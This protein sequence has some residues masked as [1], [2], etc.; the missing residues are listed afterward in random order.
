MHLAPGFPTALMHSARGRI[1]AER[2]DLRRGVDELMRCGDTLRA[3]G[4]E[5]PGVVP[6]RSDAAVLL[7]IANDTE[8]AREL[9][10]AEVELAERL[11]GPI[12]RGRAMHALAQTYRGAERIELLREALATLA[13]SPAS[14]S[15]AM[16]AV[17]LGATLRRAKQPGEARQFLADGLDVAGRCRCAPLVTRAREELQVLGVAPRRAPAYGP[18]SLTPSEVRV[19]RLA[20]EG[21]TNAE[22]AQRLFVTRKT[23]EKHLAACFRKLGIESRVEL[24]AGEL[25]AVLGP[26][27]DGP[28]KG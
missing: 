11:A 7:A 16:V 26:P 15:H 22:I 21:R 18:L 23:V 28:P 2:G 6:W 13:G 14:L 27:L 8:R 25:A 9:A 17:E 19:A 24:A 10:A 20:A 4:I 5:S 12:A 1:A 3:M